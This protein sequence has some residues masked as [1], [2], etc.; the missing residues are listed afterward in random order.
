MPAFGQED[1]GA[2]K[3]H[4]ISDLA[5]LIKNWND[6]LLDEAA[7][8][9][10]QAQ[11]PAAPPPPT[12][13]QEA[14]AIRYD[15]ATPREVLIEGKATFEKSC[16]LCHDLPTVE[17]VK[18]FPSDESLVTLATTMSRQMANLDDDL[19][20]KVIRY[21]LALRNDTAP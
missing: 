4:E 17:Q 21:L 16:A 11:V 7:T 14:A 2:L 19:A 10:P 9:I 18:G 20:E 5:T 12:P 1:G 13:E 6:S 8:H 3:A 15:A